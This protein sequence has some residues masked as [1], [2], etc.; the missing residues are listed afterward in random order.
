M[1]SQRSVNKYIPNYAPQDFKWYERHSYIDQLKYSE[2]SNGPDKYLKEAKIINFDI[3]QVQCRR[4]KQNFTDKHYQTVV[5]SDEKDKSQK[6]RKMA[7]SACI[8]SK[9]KNLFLE[10]KLSFDYFRKLSSN[11][12]KLLRNM[13]SVSN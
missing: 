3:I 11:G 2:F 1:S 13:L 4:D 5:S 10:K 6:E 7:L 12:V 8:R 9:R